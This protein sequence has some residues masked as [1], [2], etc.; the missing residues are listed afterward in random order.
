[1]RE[2][3]GGSAVKNLPTNARDAGSV[4]GLARSPGEGNSSLLQYFC[5]GNPLDREA[6][7]GTVHRVTKSQTQ[8][9]D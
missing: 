2:N 8:L 1:M 4:P 9:S 7:W 5:L 3:K 6:W